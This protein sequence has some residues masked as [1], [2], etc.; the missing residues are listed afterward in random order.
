M[1]FL[2]DMISKVSKGP[3]PNVVTYNIIINELCK[4]GQIEKAMDLIH[5]MIS[6]GHHPDVTTYNTLIDGLV[7]KGKI[8][9][10]IDV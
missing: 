5:V 9:N 2:H 6:T 1:D 3:E 8:K 10:T 4:K 7:K